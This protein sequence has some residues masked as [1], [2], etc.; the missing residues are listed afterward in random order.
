MNDK[1]QVVEEG[2][3]NG[4]H[5]QIKRLPLRYAEVYALRTGNTLAEA[6]SRDEV[7]A[8]LDKVLGVSDAPR[9]TQSGTDGGRGDADDSVSGHARDSD[10]RR[11]SEP[12]GEGS[13]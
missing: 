10:D 8:L 4:H 13:E 7:I 6:R 1:A 12:D 5:Y 2:V 11:G 9:Q 3:R